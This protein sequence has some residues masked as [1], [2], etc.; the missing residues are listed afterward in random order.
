MQ[1]VIDS[2]HWPLVHYVMPERVSD[3]DAPEH[4]AALNAVLTREQPFVLIFS[5]VEQPKDSAEFMRL[6]RK[7]SVETRAEQQRW[8]KGAVR[9]EPDESR[10][11]S[12]WRKAL[13][14]VQSRAAPYPY[15]V[16]ATHDEALDLAARWL[17]EGD[18]Q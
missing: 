13:R 2:S 17:S 11:R 9:V 10:R 5:G 18:V 16:V 8:C 4:V 15:K 3:E 1:N 6:M 7:W 14:Y 12:L